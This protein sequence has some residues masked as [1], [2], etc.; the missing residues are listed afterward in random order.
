M[1]TFAF[2]F[3]GL[4]LGIHEVEVL[5]EGDVA[6]VRLE[7]DGQVIGE[8]TSE[9]WRLPIDLGPMLRPHKL[10]AIA[11]DAK[12]QEID[13]ARQLINLPRGRAEASLLLEGPDPQKPDSARLVWQHVEYQTAEKTTFRSYRW[14]AMQ[15]RWWNNQRIGRL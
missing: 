12:G 5:V 11:L 7:L 9:P 1:I 13:T 6:A 8:L 3:L 14:L 2:L 15:P 4:V 10:E